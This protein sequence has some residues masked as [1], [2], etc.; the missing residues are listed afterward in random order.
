V[1]RRKNIWTDRA[2]LTALRAFPKAGRAFIRRENIKRL[3]QGFDVAKHFNPPYDP[4]DQR[5]CLAPDG[6]FFDTI[7]AGRASVATDRISRFSKR[8]IVLESGQ[9]LEA[10]II[11][12]A[13]GLNLQL[14]GGMPITVDG[15]QIDIADSVAYRGMLLSGIPNW[16]MAIGYT[17]S[18]WTLKVGLMCRYFIDL[19]RHMDAHGHDTVVPVAVPGMKRRPVMDLQSGYAKRAEPFLPKQ[20]AAAPWQMAMD[21]TVDA[22]ALRGPVADDNLRFGTRKP[23]ERRVESG[24]RVHV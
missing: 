1:T 17:T 23:A 20:G 4:W 21:Y 22:R 12:T 3:P 11:I 6:D 14:F 16:A 8:G 2:V 19:V 15:D 10:D 7:K 13:T 24:A 9:E 18:S 5:L